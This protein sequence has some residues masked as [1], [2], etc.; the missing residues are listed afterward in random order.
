MNKIVDKWKKEYSFRTFINS[1]GSFAVTFVFALYNGFL[2]IW[3]SSVWNAGICIYYFFL[4]LIRG[5]ILLTEKRNLAREKTEA[6]K[7]RTKTFAGTAKILLLMSFALI[8][9]VLLMVYNERPVN[10]GLI[11]A[12]AVA[13]YTTYKV[14]MA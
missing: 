11:P 5:K 12:I 9:P 8:I 4:V 6:D 13:S 3:Y 2:G 7:Y 14:V 10:M 1:T